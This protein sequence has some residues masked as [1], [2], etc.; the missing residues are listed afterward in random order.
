MTLS[1]A[2][3]HEVLRGNYREATRSRT[4]LY[5]FQCAGL[6]PIALGWAAAET[7]M[8][9]GAS[10]PAPSAQWPSG[11]VPHI[12][13]LEQDAAIFLP[14]VWPPDGC[15]LHRAEPTAAAGQRGGPAVCG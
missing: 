6:G 3:A 12:R 5:P 2:P 10:C 8:W 11:M 15:P 1:C 9:R 13:V 14:E 7:G 4:G